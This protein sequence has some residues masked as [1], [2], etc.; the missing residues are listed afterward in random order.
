VGSLV[1]V[2]R[3]YTR[4]QVLLDRLHRAGVTRRYLALLL[5]VNEGTLWRWSRG[6][7]CRGPALVSLELTVR[8]FP[9]AARLLDP[10]GELVGTIGR[11]WER[12]RD[13]R[14][15]AQSVGERLRAF[16]L[17]AA[18]HRRAWVAPR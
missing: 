11:E 15:W 2:S 5:R 1:S 3:G 10:K 17:D 6:R 16:G 14:A 4:A 12:R 9:G 7:A 13:T 8:D 18:E